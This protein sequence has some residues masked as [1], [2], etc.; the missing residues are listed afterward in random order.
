MKTVAVIFTSCHLRAIIRIA[1][2]GSE[3]A[4]VWF[5]MSLV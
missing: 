2:T 5:S 1:S 3:R 4:L